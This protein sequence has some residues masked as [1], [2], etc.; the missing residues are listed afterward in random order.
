MQ[1]QERM[2]ELTRDK[3]EKVTVEACKL[4]K[5]LSFLDVTRRASY[6]GQN[7]ERE[8]FVKLSKLL[9]AEEST[10][11]RSVAEVVIT[12]LN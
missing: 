10:I 3:Y 5:T 11:R 2:V 1:W 4:L 9:F 7:T 8:N 12:I 6:D